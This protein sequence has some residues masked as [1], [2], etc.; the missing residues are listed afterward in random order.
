[1]SNEELSEEALHMLGEHIRNL[2]KEK[3]MTLVDL[4]KAT[5][6]SPGYLS[7]V[8]RGITDPSLSS[9]HKIAN[10]LDIPAMLLLDDPSSNRSLTIHREE[11]P[12]VSISASD[13]VKYR[14]MTP[15]PNSEYMP[16]SLVLEFILQP[17]SQDFP[18][19]I[20]HNTEEIVIV[21]SGEI[22]VM[23]MGQPL[24]LKV[25]DTTILRKNV[26]HFF[27]NNGDTVATGLS[28]MTPAIWSLHG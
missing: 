6:L 8:E 14:M 25:G 12:I 20:N 7:Q 16:S 28:I 9:L 22:T 4:S 23:Q 1:M 5:E 24:C 15:L 11:Q 13:T 10:A 21:T 3:N 2:R 17:H 26:P 18:S 19:P 27:I